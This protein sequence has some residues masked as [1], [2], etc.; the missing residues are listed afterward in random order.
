MSR[1]HTESV[2]TGLK[3]LALMYWSFQFQYAIR[4]RM[5]GPLEAS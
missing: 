1:L 2:T 4:L 5:H 3:L